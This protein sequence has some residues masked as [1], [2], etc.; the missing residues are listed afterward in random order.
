M[1]NNTNVYGGISS[2]HTFRYV[3]IPGGVHTTATV[4]FRNYAEVKQAFH[5]AN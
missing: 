2:A 5:L 1:T 4:N 3:I